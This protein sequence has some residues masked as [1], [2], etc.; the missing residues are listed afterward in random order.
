MDRFLSILKEK[1]PVSEKI[2]D[3]EK[4]RFI[5]SKISIWDFFGLPQSNYLTLSKDKK[6]RMFKDYYKK[7][8]L[9][10]FGDEKYIYFFGLFFLN[11]LRL[12]FKISTLSG[13]CF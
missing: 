1:L 7:L 8:V 6:L 10:C 12:M 9:K 2:V 3:Q 13:V 5:A 4:L 11:C